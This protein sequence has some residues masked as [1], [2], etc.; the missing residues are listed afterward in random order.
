MRI[1]ALYDIH[2]NLPALEAVLQE[3][4][5][6][7]PDLIL[8]GGDVA[9]G[10]MP[11]KTVERLMQLSRPAH[12]VRGNA[13]RLLVERFDGLPP[14]ANTPAA[15][16]ETTQW[17]ARQLNQEQRDFLAAFSERAVLPVDGLGDA[18]F[19]HA[20]PRSDEEILTAA[21]PEERVRR[22]LEGVDQPLVVCGH[23][24]MQYERQVNGIRL[25]NAGSVGM[26]YGKVGA[27]WALLGPE[28]SLQ[29]TRYDLEGAAERIRASGYPQADEFAAR[30]VLQPA[31]AAEAIAIFER[32][33]AARARLR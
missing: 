12:F 31:E 19:C 18:L 13:D 10:P 26:P 14:A 8:F 11:V 17:A 23:T 21:T 29:R 1:A 3:V 20:S 27:Y 6:A 22:A 32:E 28:V 15:V 5:A 2:A 24:H 9:A 25:V 16:V 30:N 4:E 33:A 7:R